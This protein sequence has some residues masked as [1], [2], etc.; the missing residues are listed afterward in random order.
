M[1]KNI[2]I[3][4]ATKHHKQQV[5]NQPFNDA[6]GAKIFVPLKQMRNIVIIATLK[7][8]IIYE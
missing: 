3:I 1:Y 4:L 2:D 5:I 8:G 7:L 6:F